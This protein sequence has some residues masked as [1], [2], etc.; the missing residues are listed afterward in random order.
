MAL[1]WS[2]ETLINKL[3]AKHGLR[4]QDVDEAVRWHRY[5]EKW[6]NHNKYGRRLRVEAFIEQYNERIIVS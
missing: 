3:K 6:V 4:W 2:S 5:D 1:D